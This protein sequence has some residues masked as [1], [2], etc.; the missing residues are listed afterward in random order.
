MATAEVLDQVQALIRE[1]KVQEADD[2]LAKHKTELAAKPEP[3]APPPPPR[4]IGDI[5]KELYTEITLHLGSP[6]RLVELLKELEP[7]FAK[8]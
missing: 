3:D 4:Q 6:A 2:L 5:L 1:G 8:L 7:F